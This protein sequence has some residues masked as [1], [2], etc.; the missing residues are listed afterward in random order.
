MPEAHLPPA[1][2]AASC[3]TPRPPPP[4]ALD[5]DA[6]RAQMR[7]APR[8]SRRAPASAAS[9]SRKPRALYAATRRSSSRQRTATRSPALRREPCARDAPSAC[10]GG[11]I[12]VNA[13]GV[14]AAAAARR[15][16]SRVRT[17][18]SARAR[19]SRRRS[20][21]RRSSATSSVPGA[22]GLP[23]APRNQTSIARSVSSASTPPTMKPFGHV[24]LELHLRPRR[25]SATR[26]RRPTAR[27]RGRS[28]R[29]PR[30]SLVAADATSTRAASTESASAR[31][32][33]RRASRNPPEPERRERAAGEQEQRRA[34]GEAVRDLARLPLV[35]EPRAQ[36]RRRR[37]SRRLSFDAVKNSPPDVARDRLQRLRAR[38]HA[39]RLGVAARQLVLRRRRSA[40]RAG[41]CRRERAAA[42]A[43]RA[44]ASGVRAAAVARAVGDEQHRGRR[45]DAVGALPRGRGSRR[46]RP[47]RRS[48]FPRRC[49]ATSSAVRDERRGRR[50]AAARPARASRTRRRRRGT[51][52]AP[53]R[54]KLDRGRLR[55]REPRRRHVGRAHRARDVDRERAPS[56]PRAASSPSRAAARRRRSSPRA[57][58]AAARPA[59][60]AAARA[61]GRRGSAASAGFAHAA[62]ARSPLPLAPD[63]RADEQRHERAARAAS[64]AT[65]KLTRLSGRKSASSRSQSP[66]VE[67]TTWRTPIDASDLRDA[68]ALG[69][70]R[71]RRSGARSFALRVSTRSWRPVS[72]ID[73]PELARV[74]QLLLA[75]V[76]DLD[77]D[78][79]VAAGELEQRPAPVVRP[80]EV[81]DDDDERALARERVRARGSPRRATSRRPVASGRSRLL[82]ERGEQADQ[83]A[84]SLAHGRRARVRR[85][86]TSRRRAGCRGASPRGRRDRDALRDV[87]LAPVGRAEAA[88]TA[89]CRGRATS[90][91]RARRAARGRAARPCAR[92]RSSR[93]AARRR[94]GRTAG[95]ARARCPARAARER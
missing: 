70:R 60:G 20:R 55:G 56:P 86:R 52:S 35:P 85:R 61:R 95:S 40:C 27:R 87:G 76:A 15:G 46:A 64:T 89:T 17:E 9:P 77:G 75:R 59:G 69:R 49:A 53:C 68:C 36:L 5:D 42:F 6:V 79:V 92:S 37:R 47:R 23:A 62:A 4:C 73:E 30:H 34:A 31:D 93:S 80:A 83:P 33:E 16:C 39:D 67:R 50:S 65:L 12:A 25:A 48:Q 84:P 21:R 94:R 91:A 3:T 74:R 18:A 45:D 22:T 88:S 1:Q 19:P 7:A 54:A 26:A 90:R 71:P 2:T 41:S 44:A 81:G 24:E 29:K 8:G 63:V 14:R 66:D 32:D 58:R 28:V 10:P 43:C 38:R 82:A 57:R 51:S 72:G 78:D 11:K 13:V